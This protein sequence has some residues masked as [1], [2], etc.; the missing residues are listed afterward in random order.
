MLTIF[1]SCKKKEEIVDL[2]TNGFLD[3]GETTPDCGGNCPPCTATQS[4]VF[5]V[6]LNGV[7]TAMNYRSLFYDGSAWSLQMAND[8]ISMQVSLGTSGVVQTANI[9]T[10]GTY[11][12][13]N[14]TEFPI[15]QNGTYSISEHSVSQQTMSG[16]FAIDFV[17][18][19]PTVPITYDTL[20]FIGG[21]FAFFS[22]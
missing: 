11:C 9:P 22:Y 6:I 8:S 2:C 16:F 15:Q 17:V 3:P 5:S 14:G 18:Q 7:Q 4:E 10:V 13:L 19:L 12:Y 1:S 21:Q 20:S